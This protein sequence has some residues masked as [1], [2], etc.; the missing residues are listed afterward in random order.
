MEHP[1]CPPTSPQ[2]R[3]SRH[4]LSRP[5]VQI[6]ITPCFQTFS[7]MEEGRSWSPW[8]PT[9]TFLISTGS[10]SK[11]SPNPAR[12]QLW[13][14]VPS[15]SYS[16]AAEG[17]ERLRNGSGQ[18]TP[19]SNLGVARRYPLRTMAASLDLNPVRAG[20]PEDPEDD[21]CGGYAEAMRG[22]KRARRAIWIILGSTVAGWG[23]LHGVDPL[24][25]GSVLHRFTLAGIVVH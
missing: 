1:V 24:L 2:V 25:I 23:V 3:H 5:R 15:V 6:Q 4:P 13:V 12:S 20:L 9:E 10:N 8:I 22:S 11:S 18:D 19:R 14:S 7:P 16:S 17:E 21:R